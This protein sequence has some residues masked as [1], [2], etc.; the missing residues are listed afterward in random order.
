MITSFRVGCIGQTEIRLHLSLVL[1][2]PYVFFQFRPGSVREMAWSLTLLVILFGCILLHEIG[3]TL[4]ARRSGIQVHS[5]VLWPLGGIATL[6]RIPEKPLDALLIALAGP[7]VNLVLGAGLVL[8]AYGL[9][10]GELVFAPALFLSGVWHTAAIRLPLT[11]GLSNLFLAVFNLVPIYPLDGG[12]IMRA[13]LH[14]LVGRQRADQVT[15]LVAVPLAAALAFFGLRQG[16]YLLVLVSLLLVLGAS[17]LN[18]RLL[19]HIYTG[20]AALA[21]RGAYYQL[22]GDLDRAAWHYTRAIERHPNRAALYTGRAVAYIHLQEIKRARVDVERALDEDP[23]NL[24]A[25]LLR[26]ELYSLEECYDLAV[27]WCERAR[28]MR[29]DW[30]LPYADLGGI[31]LEQ[32]DLDQALP[33]LDRAI[34]LNPRFNLSHILRAIV[35]YRLGDR[36]GAL[37]DQEK[38]FKLS[39]K[40][41]LVYPEFFLPT[42]AGYLDWALE[43]YAWALMRLP[44][45]PHPYH[46]RA[47]A[48][49]ANGEWDQAVR[50]YSQAIRLAPRQADLYLGR[51]RAYQGS[52]N[53][54]LAAA[55][56]QRAE[57]LGRKPH[58]RRQAGEL[59]RALEPG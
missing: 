46:G 36:E 31:Y 41:A 35:R 12:Q 28:Q 27:E 16:D 49:R 48:L 29:P 56:F 24:L 39:P 44:D 57:Q 32:G 11:L 1:I 58:L 54:R 51:G 5:I 25:V 30:S 55:D 9:M 42:L 37:A 45:S 17:S 8:W 34:E 21:N 10:F 53:P 15:L 50:D 23:E 52:G 2:L 19:R 59:L 3:H 38:A 40:E 22:R 43:Y 13:G 4:V 7:L 14:L 6:D 33:A 20:Y 18:A 47:D 26:A